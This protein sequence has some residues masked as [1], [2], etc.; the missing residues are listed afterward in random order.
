MYRIELTD[1]RDPVGYTIFRRR[2]FDFGGGSVIT[3]TPHVDTQVRGAFGGCIQDVHT[4]AFAKGVGTLF[5][6]GG[7]IHVVCFEPFVT[8]VN[9]KIGGPH[10]CV[11]ELN[12]PGTILGCET[13]RSQH[14]KLDRLAMTRSLM[15]DERSLRYAFFRFGGGC[16]CCC[17]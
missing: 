12:L 4:T 16:G 13:A 9:A 6:G 17:C 5:S 11:A 7:E 3:E 15:G 10:P 14:R 2:Y 1:G 8:G